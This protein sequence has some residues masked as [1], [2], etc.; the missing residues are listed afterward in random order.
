MVCGLG[1]DGLEGEA[2]MEFPIELL[3]LDKG[4]EW[5]LLVVSPSEYITDLS[6]PSNWYS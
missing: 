1:D 3:S 2:Q 6:D 4:F 5:A